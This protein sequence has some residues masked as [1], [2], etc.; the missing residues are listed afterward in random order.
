MKQLG[1]VEVE[2]TQEG[3]VAWK[4]LLRLQQRT[5]LQAILTVLGRRDEKARK[6]APLTGS[7][8][9]QLYPQSPRR[10]INR[11]RQNLH[12]IPR[13]ICT[14]TAPRNSDGA[15]DEARANATARLATL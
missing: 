5:D 6:P 3:A 4:A 1:C 15:H 9:S 12:R 14:L 2:R 13:A 8:Q 7:R 11:L 10:L